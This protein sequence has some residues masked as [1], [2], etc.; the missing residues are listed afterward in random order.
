MIDQMIDK[1]LQLRDKK[2]EME[3]AH[4][5]AIAPINQ[6]L[7]KIEAFILSEMQTNG[8]TSLSVKGVGTAYQSQRTSIT[9]AEWDSYKTWIS[10]QE[11]PYRYVDRKANKTAVEEYIAEHQ[12]LPPGLNL[13][14]ELTVNVRRA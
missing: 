5:G 12:D 8:S 6:A 9:V 1:Y 2:A 7:D 11:D 10:Q 13:R 4:K 14:R 3:T